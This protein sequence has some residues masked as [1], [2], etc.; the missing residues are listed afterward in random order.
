MSALVEA[1]CPPRQPLTTHFRTVIVPPS[2]AIKAIARKQLDQRDALWPEAAPRLW[3]RRAN[4]GFATIP[5]TMPLVLQVMDGLSKG[6]PLSSTYLGLWCSTWDNSF[7]TVS[8]AQEMAHS[9]GFSGQRAEYTWAARIKLLEELG[10][11]D[12]KPGSFGAITY[13][14]LWNPHVVIREHYAKGTPGL[15]EGTYNALLARALDVGA[16][17]MVHGLDAR[18]DEVA[19]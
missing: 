11:I 12:V 18:G 14:L 3:N 16:L 8:R 19:S 4:K 9:A 6:K 17:D 5:K 10:F 1:S 7:V 2:P 13:V 15:T